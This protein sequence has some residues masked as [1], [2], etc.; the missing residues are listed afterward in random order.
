LPSLSHSSGSATVAMAKGTKAAPP[1]AARV[2]EG[3]LVIAQRLG[4]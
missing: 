2:V 3:R 4:K 1:M